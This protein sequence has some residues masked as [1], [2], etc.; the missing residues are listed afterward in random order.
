MSAPIARY[1]D[2]VTAEVKEVG[3]KWGIGELLVYRLTDFSIVARWRL[4]DIVILGDFEHEAAP[5]ISIRG[6]D[7]RLI[8]ED[9]ELKA[10]LAR[11]P[12]LVQLQQAK[13]RPA[14]RI[15]KFGAAVVALVA[16]FWGIV[17]YGSDYAAPLVP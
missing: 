14:P 15:L 8:V 11:V 5:A 7:A 2:G 9:P 17:D 10:E 12:Y 16:A 4:E 1:Y 13:P 6:S 3:A